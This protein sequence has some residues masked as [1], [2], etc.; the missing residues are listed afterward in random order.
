MLATE[1]K[2]QLINVEE[3]LQHLSHQDLRNLYKEYVNP[4]L[5]FLK[6]LLGFDKVFYKAKGV[7]VWDEDEQEYLDFLGGY[8]A[9]NF[10]HNPDRVLH[11]VRDVMERP[12]LLQ[13]SLNVLESVAAYNLAQITP[14]ALCRTFFCNSGAEAVEGAL[15]T[16]RAAT[17]KRQIIAC[18]D[19]FHGKS[20]GALTVTGREKYRTPF[21][22]LLPEVLHIP[23]GDVSALEESVQGGDVA[24]FLVEPIQGEGGIILPP[25]GYLRQVR[26]ICDQYGVLLIADEIQTGFGRTGRYFAVD[27][28]EVLPDLMCL[29]KSLGGGVMPVGAFH[30]TAEVWDQAYGGMEKCTLHTSTFGGNTLAAAAVTAAIEEL[31]EGQLEKAAEEKG[32][33]FLNSLRTLHSRYPIIK[34]IRGQGL[35]IGIEFVE[36]EGILNTLTGGRLGQVSKEYIGAMVAGELLNKHRII[37]AYTLNNPNVIRMEPPLIVTQT[38]IDRVLNALNDI[39]QRQGSFLKMT[40]A[41]TGTMLK[42]I[43]HS[44]R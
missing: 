35:M 30:T 17:G 21:Q 36:S 13:A 2:P 41:S 12:N 7:Q 25:Q 29:A 28:E 3:A 11:R 23:F 38:E 24:A 31:V 6:G 39:L 20:M 9:L 42:S 43:F 44:G 16:A 18:H 15:K 27:G 37:T 32:K 14:S 5:A 33:Y 19:S 4:G 26:E 8:G 1:K 34:E 22:P 40:L 10:G